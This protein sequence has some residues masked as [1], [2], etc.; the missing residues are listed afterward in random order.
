MSFRK[1]KAG[2]VL[3]NVEQYVGEIGNLFFDITDGILRLSDGVKPG[4]NIVGGGSALT[5]SEI[6]A[7]NAIT[8]QT[9][10]VTALRFDKQTGFNLTNLGAGEVKISMNS[11]W[12]TWQV[13]GQDSLVA[14]GEDTVT[15]VAGTNMAITTNAIAKTITFNSTGTSLPIA[16][17]SVLGGIKVGTG[18][19]INSTTGVLSATSGAGYDGGTVNNA[20]T[21]LDTTQSTNTGTGSLILSGGAGIAKNVNVGGTLSHAGLAVTNGTNI[22]QILTF[23]QSLTLTTGWVNTG[24][25]ANSAGIVTGSYIIQLYANDISAGGTNNNEYY[26]GVMSWNDAGTNDTST[27]PQDEIPLHRTGRG[28]DGTLYLRTRRTTT[29]IILEISSTIVSTSASNYVFKFRRLI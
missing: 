14:V 3:N 17:S 25:S 26:T 23:T 28:L 29:T 2:L 8:N 16:T 21:V 4:G 27:T 15:F 9:T 11:S 24:I 22:D 19:S 1:I 20:I 18:L 13:T 12:K 10:N 5:V 6:G 7:N